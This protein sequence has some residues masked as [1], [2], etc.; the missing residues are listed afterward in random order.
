MKK[1]NTLNWVDKSL[2]GLSL[3]GSSL[4]TY[5][6][7]NSQ[8]VLVH[9]M[10][11]QEGAKVIG[12]VEVANNDVRRR[13]KQSL[14]WY[15]VSSEET[16]YEMDSI[17]TGE[18]S[19][20]YIRLNG[21][22]GFRMGSN[23]MVVLSAENDEFKLDLQLGSVIADVN[24]GGELKLVGDGDDAT[25][26]GTS[27]KKSQVSINKSKKGSIKLAS[28]GDSFLLETGTQQKT[29]DSL[30]TLQLNEKLE[31]VADK[32]PI[33]LVKPAMGR[34]VWHNPD[35]PFEFR[36][37]VRK[38]NGPMT[39]Q[40][41]KSADFEKTIYEK[42]VSGSRHSAGG[43]RIEGLYYWRMVLKSQ[44]K[45]KPISNTH[46]FRVAILTSPKMYIPKDGDL[47]QAKQTEEEAPRAEV[48]FIWE[49][50]LGAKKYQLQIGQDKDFNRTILNEELSDTIKNRVLLSKGN[51]YWR[52]RVTAPAQA[53]GFWSK[54]FSFS[55]K[56]PGEISE[57]LAEK[58]QDE[59]N[60]MN[61]AK[62]SKSLP[63]YRYPDLSLMGE[64]AT[65]RLVPL[66]A[67]VAG[68]YQKTTLLKFNQKS[69]ERNPAAVS[70]AVVNPPIITWAPVKTAQNYDLEI[71]TDQLFV[72]TILRKR[73][74][75]TSFVWKA[76]KVGQF[77]WRIR[78][79]RSGDRVSEYSGANI[80][81]VGLESPDLERKIVR[82]F[83]AK[84]P[85]DFIQSG[86]P[87]AFKWDPS[88]MADKYKVVIIDEE[89]EERVFDKIVDK[90]K[91]VVE[92]KKAGRYLATVASLSKEEKRISPYSQP[93]QIVF[94]KSYK[95]GTPQVLY[96]VNG[97]TV[98]TFGG[99]RPDSM[100]LDWNRVEG[101]KNYR[102]QF[103]TDKKFKKVFVD[104]VLSKDQYFVKDIVPEGTVFWRVRAQYDTLYSNWTT[105]RYFQIQA[106][107]NP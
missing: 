4:F 105:P 84:N 60:R 8:E 55:V 59:L 50:K 65:E 88:P 48:Q 96:P 64:R 41:S 63:S 95:F 31:E 75:E 19:E 22:V 24:K 56:D 58:E 9:F 38:K 68:D 80:L 72:N 53:V 3:L 79:H 52:V 82:S 94:E 13:L 35:Q 101:A 1:K 37:D 11:V 2:V 76:A 14:L 28:L 27:G 39:L 49:Q 81:N 71:A 87:I 43:V 69:L 26:K 74:Q 7:I 36:W 15:D 91:A 54:P 90:P 67:P 66:E 70:E 46:E 86:P 17:F 89:S 12:F 25:I 57:I 102:L 77:F 47:I 98:V 32:N 100:I 29:I 16:L 23:S 85:K 30:R 61:F 6:L 21:D 93:S 78:S 33:S 99:G 34:T 83:E 92:F 106:V 62:N 51:Y 103:S 44:K 42:E 10:P 20:T 40:V 104:K 5:L 73:Q 18:N 107:K 97:T 45:A